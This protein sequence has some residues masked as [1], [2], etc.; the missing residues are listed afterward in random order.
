MKKL[1]TLGIVTGALLVSSQLGTAQ[2]YSA[3]S[4]PSARMK[5]QNPTFTEGESAA[6][7]EQT[8]PVKK[9][10]APA[11]QPAK[12][13]PA[14]KASSAPASKPASTAGTT[15][16]ERDDFN[17]FMAARK[18]GRGLCNV[19]LSPFEIPNQ[20]VNEAKRHDTIG[21]S[22]GGYLTGIPVGCGWMIYR[23]GVGLYD[24]ITAPIPT[25]TYDKSY[26]EPPYLFPQSPYS[27][28]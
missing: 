10:E 15:R 8:A 18:S 20:M 14:A 6:A 5:P 13:A 4:K 11:A 24:F 7:S 16:T 9:A 22:L 28:D 2:D 1:S 27:H 21:G 26:I 23:L 12:P 25:P 17:V 19:I 3:A